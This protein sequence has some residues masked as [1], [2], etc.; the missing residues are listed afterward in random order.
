MSD[1]LHDRIVKLIPSKDLRNAIIE[2]QYTLSDIALLST[3][4]YCAPNYHSRIE[5][6]RLLAESFSGRIK[7]YANRI[8]DTQQKM[9]DAFFQYQLGTVFELHIKDTPDAYD[10]GYLCS[11]FDAATKM[12]SLF[13][14]EYGMTENSSSKYRVVK[15]RVFSGNT[16]ET[17]AEDYLGDIS[18]LPNGVIYDVHVDGSF[19][20]DC[21]G[22]C[23]G[24]GNSCCIRRDDIP[25]PS[26]TA[27][28]DLVKYLSL[29]AGTVDFGVVLQYDNAPTSE[30]YIVPL[31][32]NAMQYH[33]FKN[34][35]YAHEHI[36]TPF[37]EKVPLDMLP[38]DMQENY[39][40]YSEYLKEHSA[41][42]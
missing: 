36:R 32:C 37:V 1:S 11:S 27:H 7:D 3:A 19:A 35:H 4:F 17:F 22:L 28:G 30:C 26:F 5:H 18:L 23:F 29:E 42:E 34:A 31:N 25:F 14:Q 33:D 41:W 40:L 15:R 38:E 39:L 8:M 24:C 12:I 20:E 16:E 9:L 10:E 21:D 13:Y 2:K 6:I